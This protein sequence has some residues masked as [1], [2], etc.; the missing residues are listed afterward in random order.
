ME[1]LELMSSIELSIITPCFNEED[2]VIDCALSVRE[3][4][5]RKLPT[6]TYEHIFVDNS[7]TDETV[8]LIKKLAN[9]DSRIKLLINSRNVGPQ[10]SIFNAFR[11]VSGRAIIPM[12][13]A[14]QQDPVEVIQD[15][16][17]NW[18]KG[19][20]VVFGIRKN[21]QENYFLKTLRTVF[22]LVIRKF[23]YYTIP[24]NAGEFMLVDRRV[25]DSLTNTNDYNPY[26]RGMIANS[27]VKST[28]VNY[29]MKA[30]TKGKSKTSIIIALDLAVNAFISTSRISA[31][32]ILLSGF[33]IA[34]FG[35]VIGLVS[36]IPNQQIIDLSFEITVLLVIGGLQMFFTGIMGE[37]V[38]SIHGQVRKEPPHFL[39]ET[40]NL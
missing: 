8:T 31:R 30:R 27:G 39:V 13:A 12:L 29:D 6:V 9:E 36:L 40:V 3:F 11:Y 38:I 2:T 26:L 32:L 25:L 7:S 28:F 35:I 14:D 24:I 20:Y 19:F 17:R 37:Y 21:R 18:R 15:F 22:Y 10:V 33:T 16:Y 4:M 5:L 1:E 23:A 34:L